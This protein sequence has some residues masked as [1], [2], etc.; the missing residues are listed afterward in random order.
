MDNIH[1]GKQFELPKL[2]GI[3]RKMTCTQASQTEDEQKKPRTRNV[4][5]QINTI[6]DFFDPAANQVPQP[7]PQYALPP[8]NMMH[9]MDHSP[10]SRQNQNMF[11]AP[12]QSFS[13]PGSQ[14]CSPLYQ[15]PVPIQPN[16]MEEQ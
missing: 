12:P 1:K 5:S 7:M 8:Q 11:A 6:P 14:V 15:V 16:V 10:Q 9:L 13:L 2:P 3:T 4:G